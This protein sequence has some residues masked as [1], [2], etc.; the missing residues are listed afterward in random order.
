[1]TDKHGIKVRE[2]ASCMADILSAQGLDYAEGTVAG[3]LLA[4][5]CAAAM[6]LPPDQLKETLGALCREHYQLYRTAL[7]TEGTA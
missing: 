3:L 7:H 2:A 5:S 4:I 1:M 6:G